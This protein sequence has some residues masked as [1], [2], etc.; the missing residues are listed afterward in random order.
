MKPMQRLS[1]TVMRFVEVR[2]TLS[3]LF[4]ELLSYNQRGTRSQQAANSASRLF[5]GDS[6][7]PGSLRA[8]LAVAASPTR[9][10]E[11]PAENT[12]LRREPL[13]TELLHHR[14]G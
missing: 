4:M 14:R 12:P 1:S 8:M 13:E 3:V 7:G 6:L 11:R 5:R 10:R 9:W 2:P